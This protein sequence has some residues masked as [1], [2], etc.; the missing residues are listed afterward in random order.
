LLAAGAFSGLSYLLRYSS[1]SLLF[2]LLLLIIL[3]FMSLQLQKNNSHIDRSALL[4]RYLL[5]FI[6]GW[7]VAASPQLVG[8]WLVHG[9]PLYN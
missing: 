4:G 6:G 9:N 1:L 3:L 7:I 5:I 2:S 8:S